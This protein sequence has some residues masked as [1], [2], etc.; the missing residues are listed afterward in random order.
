[1]IQ[2]T[3]GRIVHYVSAGGTIVPA[4]VTKVYDARSV[5]LVVFGLDP[6]AS[7]MVNNVHLVQPGDPEGAAIPYC[8]WIPYQVKKDHG[9]ES[10]ERA[11]GSESI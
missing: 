7:E 2:P 4:I 1:M 6:V 5:D 10:G 9:S 8:E 3:V 11:V